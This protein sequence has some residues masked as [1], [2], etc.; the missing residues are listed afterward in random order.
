MRYCAYCGIKVEDQ[1]AECPSCG[2]HQTI[3]ESH[4]GSKKTLSYATQVNVTDTGSLGWAVLGF[5]LPIVGLIVYLVLKDSQPKNAKKAGKFALISIIIVVIIDI[6][7]MS[8]I[9]FS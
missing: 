3:S 7:F 8:R 6:F 4:D 1:K 5:F 2:S 9:M